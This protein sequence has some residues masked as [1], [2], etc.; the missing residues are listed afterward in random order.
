MTLRPAAINTGVVFR[1]T[2]IGGDQGRILLRREAVAE[3]R[4]AT[5][6]ANDFGASVTTVEHLLAAISGMGVDNIEIEIDNA[7]VP[8][9]DGSAGPFADMI[10]AAGVVE[11]AAARKVIRILRPVDVVL[12]DRRARF[13]PHHRF[14]IDVTIEFA[15][16]AIGRQRARMAP[17]GERFREE[18]APARTF[19]FL[20]EVEAMKSAGLARGGS[21][22][23]AVVIKDGAVMNDGGLRYA[24]EFVRHKVLDAMGDLAVA[25]A[26]IIGRYVAHRPGHELN[27]AALTA[28]L[29]AT[30]A[31]RIETVRDPEPALAEER[32][33]VAV[34]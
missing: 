5:T 9:M 12:G 17:T 15:D 16:P 32:V 23:N 34:G 7:E 1:R 28:L 26:P 24:D 19:G 2:D 21:L 8:A 6:I 33:A 13:T 3:T 18:I 30:D 11:Q 20:H 27:N 4:L 25:G 14:E 29:D 22:D 10:D 31:W